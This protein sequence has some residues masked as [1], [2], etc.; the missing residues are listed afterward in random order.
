MKRVTIKQLH[1]ET[2]RLIREAAR[3]PFEVTDRGRPVAVVSAVRQTDHALF[4]QIRAL[5]GR[6]VLPEGETTKDLINAGRRI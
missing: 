3:G 1:A 4:D 6:M 5:R 2:G